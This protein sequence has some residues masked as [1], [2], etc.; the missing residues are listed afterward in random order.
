M[1]VSPAKMAEPIEMPFGLWTRVA[2][3]NHVLDGDAHWRHLANTTEPSTCVADAALCQ[4][5]LTT[6][7]FGRRRPLWCSVHCGADSR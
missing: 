6:C 4:S 7:C 5:T 3:R 2:P 1:I